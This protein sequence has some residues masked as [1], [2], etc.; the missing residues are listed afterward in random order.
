LKYLVITF[1]YR[2]NLEDG[3]A[4]HISDTVKAI[5]LLCPQI[6]V[7]PLIPDFQGN[8]H[9]IEKIAKI[10]LEVISHK[11]ETVLRPRDRRA[12]YSQSILFL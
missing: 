9:S 6:I 12:S 7:E 3:G 10:N 2:D 8:D 4:G 5:K 11:I 1:V